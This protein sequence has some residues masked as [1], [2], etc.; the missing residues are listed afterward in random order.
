MN[1]EER[2][3]LLIQKQLEAH[4]KRHPP[5]FPWEMEFDDYE[6]S[7]PESDNSKLISISTLLPRLNSD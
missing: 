4:I 3:P 6:T 2:L 7:D 1:V 5:L